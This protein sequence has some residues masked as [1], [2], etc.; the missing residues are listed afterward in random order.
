MFE[1]SQITGRNEA[2]TDLHLNS[3]D[4]VCLVGKLED[5]TRNHTFSRAKN[6]NVH[7]FGRS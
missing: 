4:Y 3:Y 1:E 7:H 5:E 6:E 2:V